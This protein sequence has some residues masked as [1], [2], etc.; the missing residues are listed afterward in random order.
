MNVSGISSASLAV[1]RAPAPLTDI[2]N[3]GK[4]MV[5]SCTGLQAL[6][7]VTLGGAPGLANS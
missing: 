1:T 5:L 3:G 6:G 4:L 2:Q 7:E